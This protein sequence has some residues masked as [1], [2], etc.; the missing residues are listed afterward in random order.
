MSIE[1]PVALQPSTHQTKIKICVTSGSC[2]AHI[3]VEVPG[4]HG[5][6]ANGALRRKRVPMERQPTEQD[7]AL[8]T[9]SLLSY[10]AAPSRTDGPSQARC[11]LS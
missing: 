3:M 2:T 4:G 8:L 7:A 1:V 6:M 9:I 10:R 5:P 11:R